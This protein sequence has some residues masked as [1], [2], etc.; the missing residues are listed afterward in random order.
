V[1]EEQALEAGVCPR[2]GAPLEEWDEPS[3]DETGIWYEVWFECRACDYWCPGTP[4]GLG[5]FR[6]ASR[7]AA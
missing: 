7:D 6:P 4:D 3:G 2:C 5:G 1:T